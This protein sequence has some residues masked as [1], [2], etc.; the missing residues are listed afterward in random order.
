RALLAVLLSAWSCQ[1]AKIAVVSYNL[2]TSHTMFSGAIADTLVEAGHTVHFFQVQQDNAIRTNGS[3]KAHRHFF[4]PSQA[5]N[6]WNDMAFRV[7][8]FKP[9]STETPS[10]FLNV[11]A[12]F[13]QSCHDVLASRQKLE[14]LGRAQDYDIGISEAYGFHGFGLLYI[15]GVRE[16]VLSTAIPFQ[17]AFA[18]MFNIPTP[19]SYVTSCL[20][21]PGSLEAPNLSYFRRIYNTALHGLNYWIYRRF[22]D[23]NTQIFRTVYPHIPDLEKL[24]KSAA[25]ILVNTPALLEMP[26]PTTHKVLHIGGI[27]ESQDRKEV[28]GA[29]LEHIMSTSRSVVVISFGTLART[30]FI[31][32]ELL[33]AFLSA[34]ARFPQVDFIWKFDDAE[35]HDVFRNHSNVHTFKW[36]PQKALLNHPNTKGFI[37]HVGLNSLLEAAQAGVPI[38]AIP[39]FTDQQYNSAIARQRG[40]AVYVDKTELSAQTIGDALNKILH[41]RRYQ[42]NSALIRAQLSAFPRQPKTELVSFINFVAQFGAPRGQFHL[43]VPT[44]LYFPSSGMFDLPEQSFIFTQSLDIYIPAAIAATLAACAAAA[45]VVYMYADLIPFVKVSIEIAPLDELLDHITYIESEDEDD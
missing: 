34:F 38:V 10:F 5:H 30:V 33:N 16:Y 7:N 8:P 36:L 25:L 18:A 40:I 37:S 44:F 11:T 42:K 26:R 29:E 20:D 24:V 45:Y 23:K 13:D 43:F 3:Q 31:E 15:L 17:P 28:L 22:A 12:S 6:V 14:R 32:G 9:F 41:G 39:L 2:G 19:V 27:A 1:G 35:L 4:I 21:G